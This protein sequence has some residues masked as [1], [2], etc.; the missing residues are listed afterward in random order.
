LF[1][2]YG[3]VSKDYVWIS[4]YFPSNDDGSDLQTSKELNTLNF[5]RIEKFVFEAYGSSALQDLGG[6]FFLDVNSIAAN[7]LLGFDEKY[8]AKQVDLYTTLSIADPE[9]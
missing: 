5:Q 4:K 7:I 8:Y 6:L 3:L 2:E 9:R 1:R